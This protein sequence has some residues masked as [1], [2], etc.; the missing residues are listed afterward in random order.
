MIIKQ[1]KALF[2]AMAKPGV[3]M[4]RTAV[5]FGGEEGPSPGLRTG[6]EP[7]PSKKSESQRAVS[8]FLADSD[9]EAGSDDG[10]GS[11]RTAP[12]KVSFQPPPPLQGVLKKNSASS[13]DDASAVASFLNDSDES[14]EFE[15]GAPEGRLRGVSRL[16]K[17]PMPPPKLTP[18]PLP[19]PPPSVVSTTGSKTTAPVGNM[20]WKPKKKQE[21][22]AE[23]AAS[24]LDAGSDEDEDDDDFGS[25]KGD[26]KSTSA[27][28]S[29]AAP[30]PLPP[31]PP[32]VVSTT[33]S[34]TTAPVGNLGWKPKKKQE[35]A[36]ELAASFLDAGSDE[37]E[38]DDDFG[39]IKG[40]SKS[41]SAKASNAAPSASQPKSPERPTPKA[42]KPPPKVRFKSKFADPRAEVAGATAVED[43]DDNDDDDSNNSTSSD[44][45]A[46]EDE[47][48]SEDFLA[49][50]DDHDGDDAGA[51]TGSDD[52]N[53]NSS[54]QPGI[55]WQPFTVVPPK[56]G[57]PNSASRKVIRANV[58]AEFA[59]NEQLYYA[60]SLVRGLRFTM[61]PLDMQRAMVN[62]VTLRS[63][64]P[65][66]GPIVK[67]GDWDDVNF[68]VVVG[69]D[70][71]SE[72]VVTARPDEING[73]AAGDSTS[74]TNLD[75]DSKAEEEEREIT[76][77]GVGA[78]FGER[79][80]INPPGSSGF[81]PRASTVRPY[82]DEPIVVAQVQ[83]EDFHLWQPLRLA[84]ILGDVPL[85]QKL[86]DLSRGILQERLHFAR[87][88]PGE[89]VFHEG[90]TG[91]RF[92]MLTRGEVQ[93]TD[94]G[95]GPVPPNPP[96]VLV[97]L[98]EGSC[99]GESSLVL[100]VPRNA[101][102]QVMN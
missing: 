86:P 94:Q 95:Y 63:C 68:Y 28:A 74:S 78:C 101:S 79:P 36:A 56:R 81:M 39:S 38:D 57:M 77:L 72:V 37:D 98:G 75:D 12:R 48:E 45:G 7:L 2:K 76:H 24:F 13:A 46:G 22:A 30:P 64:S 47:G 97:N 88:A 67:Q 44:D 59:S 73:L 43:S 8:S 25:I 61:L 40:D 35:S 10:F 89:F 49:G 5:V 3:K 52:S 19:P 92:Y 16:G 15:D 11:F 60:L 14:N 26:S 87:Y 58:P 65:R 83:V 70:E 91:D 34:K 17:E 41:T 42:K 9:E 85:L 99:F 69:P 66:D 82:G 51:K 33:G 50:H 31:P 21:S 18:P 62:S 54:S 4:P 96:R 6:Q 1:N 29:N 55:P 23:L 84:L 102:V 20:G 100:D 93:V 53:T 32:S 71:D 80:L 90:D 27:K